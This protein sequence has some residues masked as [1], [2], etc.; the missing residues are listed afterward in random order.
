AQ[1]V[2]S[3]DPVVDRRNRFLDVLLALYGEKLDQ[4]MLAERGDHA[5]KQ[6][7]GE[8]LLRAKLA[9][10]R[11]LV[12]STRNRGRGFDYLAPAS[13]H[14]VAGMLIKSRIQLG[15]EPFESRPRGDLIAELGLQLVESDAMATIGRPLSGYTDQIDDNFIVPELGAPAP[16]APSHIAAS[17]L[18][19]QRV[20]EHFLQAAETIENFRIGSL[21]GDTDVVVVCKSGDDGQWRFVGRYP[22][23]DSA[24]ASLILLVAQASRLNRAAQQLYI[25]ENS[26]LRFGRDPDTGSNARGGLPG[27]APHDGDVQQAAFIY[28][29]TITAVLV[30]PEVF[31]HD[32]AYRGW[33]RE[34]IRANTPAHI[35][36]NYC[37]LDT[38]QMQ[39]FETHYGSQ[40]HAVRRGD[41]QDI[42]AKSAL[43]QRFLQQH[44]EPR[45]VA[46][47][48]AQDGRLR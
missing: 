11:H 7:A 40:R 32:H 38:Q 3:H 42:A 12:A 17:P 4:S 19:G 46:A 14:N 21:P 24:R 34:V 43:L 45:S 30:S 18:H 29:F 47:S 33:V 48:A 35:A 25:I 15:L 10:L 20:T 2:A 6:S 1:L 23:Q 39:D 16:T 37:F 22:D 27:A 44:Q 26:M 41:L 36:V 5:S 8:R 9:L 31:A 13:P 28:D